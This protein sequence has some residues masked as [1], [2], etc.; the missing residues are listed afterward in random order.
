MI[1]E[2]SY[3]LMVRIIALIILL[4]GGVMASWIFIIWP[5]VDKNLIKAKIFLNE[6]FLRKLWFYMFI[7]MTFF[8]M[9]QTL[10]LFFGYNSDVS[11]LA[12]IFKVVF[13]SLIVL[14]LKDYFALVRSCLRTVV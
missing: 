13:V 5:K 2:N 10:V 6:K 4:I 7:G 1:E 9:N 11:I 8:A 12:E 14:V 3:R